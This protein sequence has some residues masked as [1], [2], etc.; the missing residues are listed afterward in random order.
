M[1]AVIQRVSHCSLSI[2]EELYSEIEHG[3]L[4]LLGYEEAD[5]QEDI[6]WLMDKISKQRIFSDDEGK[7]NLSIEDV[8]GSLMLV[9]QFTLYAS[10]KKGNRP[11]YLRSASPSLAE[12]LYNQTLAY[13]KL[14]L[15]QKVQQ[16]KF[17][18]D[19]QITFT[20]DGPVTLFMDTKNK[21]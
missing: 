1:R 7:M 15:P 4:V 19:M 2:G 21:E 14:L 3:L 8:R 12:K 10:T 9:S 13:T 5:T 18:A 6:K 17:G 20:N 11:S 16:G